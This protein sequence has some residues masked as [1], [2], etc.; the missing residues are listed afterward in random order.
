MTIQLVKVLP[1]NIFGKYIH[2]V[3]KPSSQSSSCSRCFC[4]FTNRER[5]ARY[6]H[7]T[8]N[9][10]VGVR[11]SDLYTPTTTA[12]PRNF[13]RYSSRLFVLPSFRWPTD[14][15]VRESYYTTGRGDQT[16]TQHTY[17]HLQY[18]CQHLARIR[19]RS[20]RNMQ[21]FAG[22]TYVTSIYLSIYIYL[23]LF[24]ENPTTFGGAQIYGCSILGPPPMCPRTLLLHLFS[25]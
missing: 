8:L 17:R 16:Q 6:L 7:R 18:T 10:I 13:G 5:G 14:P 19:T 25:S 24:A 2:S 23:P 9:I 15:G 22:N 20:I 12:N 1:K 3:L 4:A 11:C 21:P